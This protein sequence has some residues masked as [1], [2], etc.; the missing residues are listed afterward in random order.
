MND[1]LYKGY[2][3]G[4]EIAF[5][6][7]VT[8]RT[9]N[10]IVVQHNCDPSAA[11][12]LG[13]AVTG[14]L[15][16]AATL[17]AGQR[18]NVCWKYQGILRTVIVDAGQDG[19]V[20]GLISP[21]QLNLTEDNPDALY[22]DLGDLQVVTSQGG[23]VINSGTTPVPLHDVDKDLA[24]YC[25]ISDQVETGLNVMIGFNADPENP[26]RLCQGWMIQALPG[27]DLERF[28]RIRHRME[29]PVFRK[30]LSRDSQSDSYFETITESLMTGEPDYQGIHLEE[31]PSPRFACS[32]NREKMAAVVRTLSIPERMELVQK[33][34]TVRIQCRFCSKRY[35]LTVDECIDAWN[36]KI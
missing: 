35:E 21:V 25:C 29:E 34:E 22:G 14:A 23:K 9:I 17:P 19:T 12:I 28:D 6:Y 16:R 1:L 4:L 10:E 11:H 2:F 36:R 26:V 13:R 8:T 33:K 18:M 15:M 24:Y 32:C 20:R 3:K 7:A 30:R 5:T 31:S 27:T